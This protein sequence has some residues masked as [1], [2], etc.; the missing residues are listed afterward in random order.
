[1]SQGGKSRFTTHLRRGQTWR[2]GCW[3]EMV[4]FKQANI[5]KVYMMKTFSLNFKTSWHDYTI[6]SRG[7]GGAIY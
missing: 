5:L 2:A 4:S 3:L 6:I 1:M 7:G